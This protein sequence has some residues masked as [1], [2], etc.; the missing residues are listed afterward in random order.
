MNV[1]LQVAL[2]IFRDIADPTVKV[3]L[4]LTIVIRHDVDKPLSLSN[5]IY[6]SH[7]RKVGG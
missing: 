6:R 1:S 3:L 5:Q 2:E 4:S 7:G